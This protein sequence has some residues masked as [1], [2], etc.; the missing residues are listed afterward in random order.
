MLT[1]TM[2]HTTNQTNKRKTTMKK[3]NNMPHATFTV[4]NK[5]HTI[6]AA[7]FEKVAECV[8][9][10]LAELGKRIDCVAQNE[11]AGVYREYFW[12]GENE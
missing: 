3:E 4:N 7:T 1:E 9:Q 11:I 8:M 10:T 5:R 6:T 2:A 12:Q